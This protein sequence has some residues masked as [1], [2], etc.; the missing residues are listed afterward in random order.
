MFEEPAREARVKSSKSTER[1]GLSTLIS[2][3]KIKPTE[4]PTK[5]QS[6]PP[7]SPSPKSERQRID[8]QESPPLLQ[9]STQE[10]EKLTKRSEL[11]TDAQYLKLTL[12]MWGGTIGYVML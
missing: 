4:H 8:S 9:V 10:K 11:P 5:S 2:L 3:P 6:T 1:S 12:L 7:T